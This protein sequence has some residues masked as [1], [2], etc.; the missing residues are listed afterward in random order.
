M[1]SSSVDFDSF[2]KREGTYSGGGTLPFKHKLHS[3]K[4]QIVINCVQ[5]PLYYLGNVTGPFLL[6]RFTKR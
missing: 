6:I 3:I 1:Y 2:D 4:K 5:T